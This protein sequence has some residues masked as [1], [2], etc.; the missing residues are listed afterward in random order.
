MI[1]YHFALVLS[2]PMTQSFGESWSSLVICLEKLM[3]EVLGKERKH[4]ICA[5]G[6][7]DKLFP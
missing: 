7:R 3:G 4:Q 5:L 2:Y 1:C 6:I